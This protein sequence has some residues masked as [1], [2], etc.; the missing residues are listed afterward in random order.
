MQIAT[1]HHE[2]KINRYKARLKTAQEQTAAE[3]EKW[4]A[5]LAKLNEEMEVAN[6]RVHNAK[7]NQR[8]LVQ[9][10]LDDTAEVEMM[11]QNYVE[12]LEGENNELHAE[13]KAALSDK[14]AAVRLAFL[15]RMSVRRHKQMESVRR[16]S[17]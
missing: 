6:D 12:S 4:R 13:L 1:E 11:L 10:H 2:T 17:C 14:R 8:A 15:W 9:Q 5:K 7:V 16:S 3:K